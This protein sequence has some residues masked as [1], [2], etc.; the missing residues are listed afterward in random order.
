M[1]DG[2]NMREERGIIILAQGPLRYIAMARNIS[3]SL[4][5]SNPEISKTLVTD[6]NAGDLN[7]FYDHI[8]PVK[9][10]SGTGYIQKLLIYEYSPYEKTLFIDVDCLVIRNIDW[11]FK[12]FE[13]L[14]VSVIGAKKFSGS[15]IGTSVEKLR[16]R[17]GIDYLLSFN[18][19]VYYFERSETARKV[20][21][22]A[23]DIFLRTYDEL[24]L[25]KFSGK[26]GDEPVM[27]IAM[28]KHHMEPIDD[29]KKGMY[30]PIGQAG[31]FRMESLKGICEFYKYGEKVNPAIMH[32]GGGY[33]EAFHYRR[34]I[35]KIKIFH[36]YRR[37]PE[38][39]SGFVNF[40]FN[41][42]YILFVLCYRIAR[43]IFKGKKF[44]MRPLIP[45]FRFE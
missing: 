8:V 13:K 31:E 12:R 37:S 18:G 22:D 6:S 32:F 3:M 29:D 25:I 21:E 43:F 27:S 44:K 7:F 24:G 38:A 33:P 15:L 17:L 39:I 45:M 28:A 23:R 10:N 26:P 35:L 14:P 4:S 42:T 34:E 2:S 1:L 30:T 36:K 5:I 11:L 40:L 9:E 20:F 41:P 16:D 19:G